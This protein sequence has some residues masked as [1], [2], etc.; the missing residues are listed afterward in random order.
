MVKYLVLESNLKIAKNYV[1]NELL[2]DIFSRFDQEN[3]LGK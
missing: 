3:M 1:S 2:L